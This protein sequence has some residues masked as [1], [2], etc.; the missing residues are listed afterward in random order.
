VDEYL[1]RAM[2]NAGNYLGQAARDPV[3]L[4]K[5]MAAGLLGL[6]GDV[7]E[8]GNYGGNALLGLLSKQPVTGPL[9]ASLLNY[10]GRS[11][12]TSQELGQAFGADLGSPGYQVGEIGAP[13][14]NDLFRHGLLGMTLFHGTPHK[15]DMF[16]LSKIGTGEGAQ[17]Y[18]H[19]LYFAENPKV[20]RSYRNKLTPRDHEAEEWIKYHGS[21]E[22]ALEQAK[23]DRENALGQFF[24]EPVPPGSD[25]FVEIQEIRSKFGDDVL[26]GIVKDPQRFI[27]EQKVWDETIDA[28]ENY[29]PGHLY[30]VDI[31]DSVIDQM[32]DWDAPLSEQSEAVKVA[33]AKYYAKEANAP[34]EWAR[35]IIDDNNYDT[36]MHFYRQEAARFAGGKLGDPMAGIPRDEKATSEWLNSI[37]IPG[38]RFYD[39]NSRLS[40]RPFRQVKKEFLK[41][42]PEDAE[43]DDLLEL[44]GTGYFTKE[45]DNVIREL[46]KNDWL[47]FD[48]P[49]QAI[50]AAYADNV[51]NWDPTDSLLQALDESAGGANRTRNIVV[52]DPDSSIKSVKRDG[53]L[54]Y[55]AASPSEGPPTGVPAQPPIA[56]YR[57][58][59]NEHRAINDEIARLSLLDDVSKKRGASI[60]AAAAMANLP[61]PSGAGA[62]K[63]DSLMDRLREINK[64]LDE[65]YKKN[66]EAAEFFMAKGL[67]SK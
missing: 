55:E 6:S 60:D 44:V 13:D 41:E 34:Y 53:E 16:D 29:S 5:G 57:E 49:S 30:E 14:M 12:A 20:A 24:S 18:G 9:A 48:Y 40:A 26:N 37:G 35:E 27:E 10:Q 1:R 8:L 19:G 45:Q 7:Q 59:K 15:F 39:G 46:Q 62:D 42:L 50:N 21:K 47:G 32:L 43:F 28:I 17:A 58:L 11:G 65:I 51:K 25:R 36:G 52:F 4:G 64:E 31:D 61:T 38:I 67:L 3:N 23:I 2:G 22:K 54:V 63:F 66:P 56:R 33:L